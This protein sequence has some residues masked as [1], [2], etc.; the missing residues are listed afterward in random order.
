[1]FAG[2]SV[3]LYQS[4]WLC[5]TILHECQRHYLLQHHFHEYNPLAQLNLGLLV[6]HIISDIESN[7]HLFLTA[8]SEIMLE[9]SQSLV[10][11]LVITGQSSRNAG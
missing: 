5:R 9:S 1:M 4:S 7:G 2:C 11:K 3:S 8:I 10:E 6:R